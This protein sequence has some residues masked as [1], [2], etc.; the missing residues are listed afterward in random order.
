M[1]TNRFDLGCSCIAVWFGVGWGCNHLISNKLQPWAVSGFSHMGSSSSLA[2]S[3]ANPHR[4]PSVL[5]TPPHLRLRLRLPSA[6]A[7]PPPPP[8]ASSPRSPGS[9]TA[10]PHHHCPLH[11]G[12]RISQGGLEPTP[13]PSA[14][15]RRP[16]QA[17]AKVTQ[18][19][20]L[21]SRSDILLPFPSCS[22]WSSLIEG[23]AGISQRNH[24][25][26]R[27]FTRFGHL[28]HSSIHLLFPK[29]YCYSGRWGW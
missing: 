7:M 4:L 3:Q 6:T 24:H 21:H 15:I 10:E 28:S 19:L 29:G 2:G 22:C 17:T 1:L 5:L 12:R 27:F 9:A 14:R 13:P 16:V 25:F 18:I 20:V 23:G 26:T 8:W 11:Y